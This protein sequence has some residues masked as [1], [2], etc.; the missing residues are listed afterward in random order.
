MTDYPSIGGINRIFM[1]FDFPERV[2]HGGTGKL[3]REKTHKNLLDFSASTNP[4]PP[5]VP[6]KPDPSVLSCY[7]DDTYEELKECIGKKFSR[8]PS[9]ICV[10]NGSIELIR[11]FCSVVFHEPNRKKLFFARMPTF[12]EY[13]LSARLS[14][15]NPTDHVE[16][17]GVAFLCNPNNPTGFLIKRTDILSRMNVLK[18]SGT[19]LFCDEAFIEL[20]DPHESVADLRDPDLFV[21]RSLT[22]SFSVPGIRFG[23]GFGDAD[24]IGKIET[25]RSPWTVNAFAESY[26]ME[27]FLHMDEL[28]ASRSAISRERTWLV[29]Q[30]T[31]L[32]LPC[33]PSSA[34]YLLVNYGKNVAPLCTSLAQNSI[35]VRDCT[36]FGLPECIRI[37]VRTHEENVQLLEV[38]AAC[39][40]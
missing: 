24:L 19:M 20:S 3:L 12:G 38:M 10:G 40:R 27:A 5:S 15:A 9:E 32:G 16:N 23:Y 39:L 8:D 25:A 11:V 28:A 30:I 2:V 22:K 34:N 26:A 4:Y 37:A 6:W 29:A 35:L 7:P 33:I 31:N 21:L 13:A 14:G 36:S 18:N 17:A 1:A